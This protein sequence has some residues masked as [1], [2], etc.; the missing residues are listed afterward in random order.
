MQS[1]KWHIVKPKDRKRITCSFHGCDKPAYAC[2]HVNWDTGNTTG[3]SFF[4]QCKEHAVQNGFKQ[5]GA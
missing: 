4:Y 3:I 2:E 1:N 5:K